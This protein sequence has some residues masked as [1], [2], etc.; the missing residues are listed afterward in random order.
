MHHQQCSHRITNQL[1]KLKQVLELL[2]IVALT[3]MQT[4]L[5]L[6]AS[7]VCTVCQT[8][9]IH[10]MCV[11]TS[12]MCAAPLKFMPFKCVLT[13]RNSLKYFGL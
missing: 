1:I 6:S 8:E 7:L 2:S 10:A 12:D 9:H 5:S 4:S 11:Y 3:V 13:I